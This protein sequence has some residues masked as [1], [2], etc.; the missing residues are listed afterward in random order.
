MATSPTPRRFVV[1][2]EVEQ[3]ELD[4]LLDD[5]GDSIASL[6]TATLPEEALDEE[7]YDYQKLAGG[8][9]AKLSLTPR[10]YQLDALQRWVDHDGRGVVV[11]PTGAGK[12]VVALMAIERT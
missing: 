5:T 12:T 6:L 1:P 9:R 8:Y 7:A 11:L 10:S 3:H 4:G 2:M